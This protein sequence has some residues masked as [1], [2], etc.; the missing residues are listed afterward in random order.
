[1][2]QCLFFDQVFNK[3]LKHATALIR[4]MHH[5]DCSIHLCDRVLNEFEI[6]M[7]SD[8]ENMTQVLVLRSLCNSK[9]RIVSVFK[10]IKITVRFGSQ[11]PKHCLL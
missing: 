9:T 1:M 6:L 11:R 10:I 8:I 7:E 2:E 3:M 5:A 4:R